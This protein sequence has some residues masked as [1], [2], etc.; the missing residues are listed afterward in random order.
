MNKT[1][2]NVLFLITAL[3]LFFGFS[4]LS[5]IG[6]KKEATDEKKETI[7]PKVMNNDLLFKRNTILVSD[8]ERALTVY[9][10]I[11]G[12][13]IFDIEESDDDSYSYP[14]FKIPKEAKIKFATLNTPSQERAMAITEVKGVTL[15]RPADNRPIM[16]T[17]VIRVNGIEDVIKKIQALGL[18]TTQMKSVETERLNYKEVAFI[19]YDGHLMVL[20]ETF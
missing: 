8:L 4:K 13:T 14:V 3:V 7:N 11:L 5:K 15:P 20:Y 16:N 1:A 19:D 2:T 6:N 9:R 12:F 10:D 17:S 18:E